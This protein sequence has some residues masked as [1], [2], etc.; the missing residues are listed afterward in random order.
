M[1]KDMVVAWIDKQQDDDVLKKFYEHILQFDQ[2]FQIPEGLE[3]QS[4]GESSIFEGGLIDGGDASINTNEETQVTNVN[5]SA[6]NPTDVPLDVWKKRAIRILVVLVPI[7]GI[8][9]GVFYTA[10]KKSLEKDI[11]P[12]SSS[13]GQIEASEIKLD[14]KD[15]TEIV[16]EAYKNGDLEVVSSIDSLW[17]HKVEDGELTFTH[18]V[19]EGES[20]G[21]IANLYHIT[22]QKIV[23]I[24]NLVSKNKGY[25]IHPQQR[26][27]IKAPTIIVNIKNQSIR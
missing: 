26:L 17:M 10:P 19:K 4:A 9:F 16:E 25:V 2:R 22:V 12:A 27:K 1:I 23:E 11:A 15:A 13:R 20:V 24:N 18:I 5:E 8:I 21:E 14:T 3:I 7:C 6:A